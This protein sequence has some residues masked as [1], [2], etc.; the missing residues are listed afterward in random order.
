MVKQQQQAFV[1]FD[2]CPV[3]D[4]AKFLTEIGSVSLQQED[5][6]IPIKIKIV[7]EEDGPVREA[8]AELHEQRCLLGLQGS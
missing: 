7:D 8:L 5:S 6:L 2:Q 1:I 3:S 4:L